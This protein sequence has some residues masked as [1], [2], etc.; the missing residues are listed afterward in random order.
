MYD[1][2]LYTLIGIPNLSTVW[3]PFIC[4]T[5]NGGQRKDAGSPL[6]N[7]KSCSSPTL[8]YVVYHTRWSQTSVN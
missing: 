5:P 2:S 8:F 3:F 4:S 1:A 6:S 7:F